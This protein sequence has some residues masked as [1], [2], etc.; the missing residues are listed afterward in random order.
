M[1][2][3]IQVV[4][5]VFFLACQAI[6]PSE[7]G[8]KIDGGLSGVGD[9]SD[10]SIDGGSIDAG[11]IDSGIS[12][13]RAESGQQG[14]GS[15]RGCQVCRGA[16][17]ICEGPRQYVVTVGC[18]FDG[19]EFSP[20]TAGSWC[21]EAPID[22][23]SRPTCECLLQRAQSSHSNARFAV[24]TPD[25]GLGVKCPGIGWHCSV[26]GDGGTPLLLCDTP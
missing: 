12:C 5:L 22:C 16:P 17:P 10:G 25:G 8:K 6:N 18:E 23:A 15:V 2:N 14:Y 1:K 20:N 21:Y 9:M 26:E 4:S 24:V 19:G 11:S 13:A 3:G 7:D